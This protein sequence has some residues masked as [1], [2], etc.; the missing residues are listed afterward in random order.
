VK[1]QVTQTSVPP[2]IKIPDMHVIFERKQA[3]EAQMV[4]LKNMLAV[5]AKADKKDEVKKIRLDLQQTWNNLHKLTSFMKTHFMAAASQG[6]DQRNQQ[7]AGQRPTSN[8]QAGMPNFSTSSPMPPQSSPIM[9]PKSSPHMP[10]G[11]VSAGNI[12]DTQANPHIPPN[13]MGMLQVASNGGQSST[14]HMLQLPTSMSSEMAAQMQK[15]VDQNRGQQQVI[16][17][18]QPSGP[19]GPPNLLAGLNTA[20]SG[21]RS[22]LASWRGEIT[23]HGQDPMTQQNKMANAQVIAT[24]MRGS[25]YVSCYEMHAY[26]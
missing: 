12:S 8:D 23:W 26:S 5:A 9:L 17:A 4:S 2:Q 24:V 1:P 15:L 25:M 10:S 6:V 11:S 21:S 19:Q 20:S 13:R 22:E 18:R 7:L 3:L 16:T 14:S